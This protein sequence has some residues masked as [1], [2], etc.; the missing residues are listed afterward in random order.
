LARVDRT[1]S[2]ASR[3]PVVLVPR[4][5]YPAHTQALAAVAA[6]LAEDGAPVLAVALHPDE[7][8]SEV[9]AIQR[10]AAG[11]SV[12]IPVDWREARL[13]IAGA[14]AVVSTRLHALV[15]AAG[16][17]VPHAGL[18]YDPKVAGFLTES[19]GRAFH[20]PLDAE[21]IYRAVAEPQPMA[22]VARERL[23][24]RAAAGLDWLDATLRGDA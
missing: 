19:G 10:A 15:F 16:A 1:A 24:A 9:R 11:A 14:R 8:A 5:G 17:G 2:E 3:L 4:S 18:V 6:R 22:A 13:L 21:D 20:D 7:D 23:V 12:R